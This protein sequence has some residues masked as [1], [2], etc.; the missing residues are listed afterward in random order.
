M[1]FSKRPNVIYLTLFL[2]FIPIFQSFNNVHPVSVLGLSGETE[3]EREESYLFLELAQVI[4]EAE[5]FI[6]NLQAGEPGKPLV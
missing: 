4:L 5:K 3:W 1:R 2:A 6:C